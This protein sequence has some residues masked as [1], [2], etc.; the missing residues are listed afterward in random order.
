MLAG[1]SLAWLM[2][3]GTAD[4]AQAGSVVLPT[5]T[6]APTQ[7]VHF[8]TPSNTRVGVGSSPEVAPRW[9]RAYDDSSLGIRGSGAGRTAAVAAAHG[10]AFIIVMGQSNNR[11]IEALDVTTGQRVWSRIG[12]YVPLLHGVGDNVIAQGYGGT[13]AIAVTSITA[14][15]GRTIWQ[16]KSYVVA[17]QGDAVLVGAQDVLKALAATDGRVRW[18]N[19]DI[20]G[21][22]NEPVLY[23][24]TWL[25][26]VYTDGA[27]LAETLMAVDADSGKTLWRTR[28]PAFPIGSAGAYVYL[29]TDDWDMRSPLIF[30]GVP[31]SAID[32][33]TGEAVS[34]SLLFPKSENSGQYESSNLMPIRVTGDA[35]YFWFH[36]RFFRYALN[37]PP[38]R[39]EPIA[40]DHVGEFLGGPKNGWFFFRAEDGIAMLRFNGDQPVSRTIVLDGAEDGALSISGDMAYFGDTS[41]RVYGLDTSTL[42]M[43]LRT[44][45][46]CETPAEY[47]NGRG[48][49]VVVCEGKLVG[50]P[51]A[52]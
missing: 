4:I 48:M 17:Y 1:A 5:A 50:F 8:L 44:R 25:L 9:S 41:G 22:V 37:I 49:L 47:V 38:A 29:R 35:I 18:V 21:S 14:E 24:A 3:A 30:T 36:D 19:T 23:G 2:F 15:T 13:S 42:E 46:A 7:N 34:T 6:A 20:V 32:P 12:H 10:F 39:K 33:R 40:V 52:R 11:H 43:R 31:I 51:L 27:I 16:S 28:T 45:I 26:P